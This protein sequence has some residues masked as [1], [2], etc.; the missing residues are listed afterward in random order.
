[1][2]AWFSLVRKE[3]RVGFSAFL[4]PIIAFII[5]SG[6]TAY[7]SSNAGF[8]FES[9]TIVAMIATGVQVFYLVYYLLHSLQY[10]KKRLHLWLHNPMPGYAL[11]LAKVVSGLFFMV[12][13]MIITA[14]TFFLSWNYSSTFNQE[15]ADFNI[16]SISL[17]GGSHLILIALSFAAVFLFFWMIFL[18][19]HSKLGGFVSF[20]MT[21]V[22]FIALASIGEWVSGTVFVET[23]TS[24]GPVQLPELI[25]GLS[26]SFDSESTDV[27]SEIGEVNLYIGEYIFECA[28]ALLLFLGACWLLERKVEV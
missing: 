27:M 25:N 9:I 11:L 13:T 14:S 15:I 22:L 8:S 1:M 24:W 12:I 26:F 28:L 6:V 2:S 19:I 7:F 18:A 4:I 3:V 17:F 16:L 20:V 10:E 5:I 21:F 23:I